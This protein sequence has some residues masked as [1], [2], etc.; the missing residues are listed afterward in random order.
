MGLS[1]REWV[2][3]HAIGLLSLFV[4]YATK[5]TNHRRHVNCS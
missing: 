5:Y 2:V 4:Y 3:V 1:E